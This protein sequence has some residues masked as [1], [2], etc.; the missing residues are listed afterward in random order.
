MATRP[1]KASISNCFSL[2]V[3]M[4]MLKKRFLLCVLKVVIDAA[5]SDHVCDVG[6]RASECVLSTL[7]HLWSAQV[8][9]NTEN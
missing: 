5:C 4:M 3:P 1:I 9:F 6:R 7:G 8:T 2:D